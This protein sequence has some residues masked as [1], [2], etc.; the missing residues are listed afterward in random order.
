MI[1]SEPYLVRRAAFKALAGIGPSAAP[2]TTELVREL[3]RQDG[4]NS[5][6]I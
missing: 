1:G 5:D 2:A 3:D 6:I 4:N